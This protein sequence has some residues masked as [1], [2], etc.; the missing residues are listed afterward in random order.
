M[1]LT[2]VFERVF[3]LQ[4]QCCPNSIGPQRE[5]ARPNTDTSVERRITNRRQGQTEEEG[6]GNHSLQT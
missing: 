5:N 2:T 4:A 1:V 6:Y 3:S